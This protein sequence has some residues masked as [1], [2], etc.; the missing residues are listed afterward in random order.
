MLCTPKV[1]DALWM[2]AWRF[3]LSHN[4]R[5]PSPKV[6][7]AF[8]FWYTIQLGR[9]DVAHATHGLSGRGK[10]ACLLITLPFSIMQF[11][12]H[13]FYNSIDFPIYF[14]PDCS[15]SAVGYTQTI[16]KK[17]T[18]QYHAIF[19]KV[20]FGLQIRGEKTCRGELLGACFSEWFCFLSHCD[21]L[22]RENL[23]HLL[24]FSGKTCCRGASH[25]GCQRAYIACP[26]E[27]VEQE[28]NCRLS[29]QL[30]LLKWW[31]HKLDPLNYLLKQTGQ[32]LVPAPATVF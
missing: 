17:D 14:H 9:G 21:G 8:L 28:A 15:N 32:L 19:K 3:A 13:R 22:S 16:S 11:P 26:G 30:P 27:G 5:F 10:T 7:H 18:T 2:T 12:F 1:S 25:G 29:Y 20:N 6:P 24:S 31:L 4:L 23:I